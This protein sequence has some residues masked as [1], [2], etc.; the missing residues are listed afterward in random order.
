VM[1]LVRK[2]PVGLRFSTLL[3]FETKWFPS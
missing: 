2:T 3:S 1:L